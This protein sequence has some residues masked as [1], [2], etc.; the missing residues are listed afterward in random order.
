MV[1]VADAFAGRRGR[2]GINSGIN[3]GAIGGRGLF[4]LVEPLRELGD[5]GAHENAQRAEK[6]DAVHVEDA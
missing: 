1:R 6:R 3:S 2:L 4:P 5:A